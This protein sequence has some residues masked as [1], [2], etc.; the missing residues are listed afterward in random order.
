MILKNAPDMMVKK[1]CKE[2]ISEISRIKPI[3]NSN[4]DASPMMILA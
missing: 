2:L 1:D 3:D 4:R